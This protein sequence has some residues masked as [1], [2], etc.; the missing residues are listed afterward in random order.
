MKKQSVTATFSERLF[1]SPLT[2]VALLIAVFFH[3]ADRLLFLYLFCFIHEMGHALVACCFSCRLKKISFHIYGFSADL[4]NVEYRPFYQQFLIY[5]AGP[6]TWVFGA[7]I[8]FFLHRG[9]F[10]NLYA[11]KVYSG[12][13]VALALFN[14]LPL[15]PLDGGRIT[16]ICYRKYL[17]VKKAF[18]YRNLWTFFSFIPLLFS[19]AVRKQYIFMIL[20]TSLVLISSLNAKRAYVLYLQNRLWKDCSFPPKC[21]LEN[22]VY[23]FRDNFYFSCGEMRDESQMIP[24]MILREEKKARKKGKKILSQN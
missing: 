23:H 19:L 18:F 4:E 13:N 6:A 1:I 9:E 12:D 20:M 7:L 3:V 24:Q 2:A 10:L 8:L 15:Y 21:N 17:P 22:E 16:E 5:A 11:Y 14:L